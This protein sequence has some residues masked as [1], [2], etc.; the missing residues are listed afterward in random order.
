MQ[1]SAALK[2]AESLLMH[3]K[4]ACSRIELKGSIARL[5]PEPKDW[6]PN[7]GN[8]IHSAEYAF[9]MEREE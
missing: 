6:R 2:V 9:E 3:L 5:K 7:W 4:P 1:Y 8:G